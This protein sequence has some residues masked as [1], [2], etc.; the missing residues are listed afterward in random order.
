MYLI[1]NYKNNLTYNE[2]RKLKKELELLK[3]DNINLIISPSN[4][5]IYSFIKYTLA[6][7]DISIYDNNATGEIS[8]KQLKS[9]MVDYVLIGH[10]E[11][12]KYFNEDI[13]MLINKIK[14]AHENN[15]KVIYCFTSYSKDINETLINIE[16]EYNKIKDYLK[17]EDL[18][19][20]EPEWAI[21]NINQLDYNYIKEVISYI[22]SITNKNIIYGGSVNVSTIDELLKIRKINGFLVSTIAS[23]VEKL[24][25][26]INKLT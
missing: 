5:F 13:N 4:P 11:R 24:Q 14:K 10:A 1:C 25:L 7:Q 15:I 2:V 19:A 23:D 20:F 16:S 21:G 6:S 9:L 8:G 12:R 26:V 3:K 17:E 22:S 18:I